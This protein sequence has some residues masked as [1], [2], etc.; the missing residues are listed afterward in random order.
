M[1][2]NYKKWGM[3]ALSAFLWMADA[4]AQLTL[5]K[6]GKA[7]S[8]IVLSEKSEINRQAADLLQEFVQRISGA[9]LP[10]VEGKA[11]SGDVVI[12][13]KS[14]EAGEDGFT[15][16][17]E[18][19]QLKITSGGDKGSIY[20]V[21][22]LLE[23]YMGVSYYAYQAYTLTPSK[24]IT[25]PEIHLSETPA[26]RYRQSFSYG[27]DDPIYKMWFRLE[28][29][30]DVFIDNM[31]VHTFDRL[32]P[33][34]VYGKDHPEYY[35][36]ING[37]HRPGNHSQ[38]CLTNPD[39][40]DFVVKKLDSIFK[41]NPDKKLISVSQN[42]G[43]NTFCTCENCRKVYEEEGSPAGAYIRFM[44]KLAERFPDKEISTLA[45]LFTMHPPK[46]VKPLPNVNIMLCD[47][48]CM[49]EV[50]LTDNASGRDFVKALEGWSAISNNIFVWDYGINFDNMVSCFPNFHVLQKNIQLF[51]KNHVTMHFS[52]VNGSKGTDFSEMRAY[53]LGKLM[54]DPYQ[55]A[56]S[57]MRSFMDGYY[58]AAAPYLYQYQKIM[59]GGLLASGI[60]LWIYDSPVTH[61]NGMLNDQLCKTYDELFD[62]A[63]AAVASDP[64]R[65]DR[66]Q[67]SRLSLIYSELEIARTKTNQDVAKVRQQLDYFRQQCRK[68]GIKSL[69]E[70]SNAPEDYCDLYEKRFLPQAEKSKALGAKVIWLQKPSERYQKIA[71]TALTDGL[72]GGTTFV[73][74]WVGWE[75]VDGSFILDLGEEQEF[76]SVEAD[77]LHQ[78]GQWILLPEK[79]TYSISTDNQT[80]QPFGSFSFAEDRAPQV[81]FVGGKVTSDKPV[82][83]RYIKVEVDA[84][85]MCP[86]WHYGVGHPAW[87]FVDEVTVL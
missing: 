59:Q 15:L 65:L 40:Y 49:R 41:A 27:C 52:Q 47:I 83:A 8:R 78:L 72:F 76:S 42:D 48:D 35:S 12:G 18:Q 60:N 1:K 55:N 32:M 69:N 46:K 56:D 85:G 30:K 77:F 82:K 2:L 66:V 68:F 74:S 54:W 73:E 44:N 19:N 64:V 37:E 62:Q 45:Y 20:G 21:V 17:T 38:W 13:G 39:V 84:I 58:G 24:T 57:L 26:F 6:D 23:K 75:G 87:F 43:N 53:M 50:P 71:D 3:V 31:W 28:E 81:K 67:L 33:S 16:C 11:K 63:E 86:A 80:Y 61:K 79:V 9:S 29:P 4:S 34:D 36:Y 14:A 70:R 22:T 25:L 51:K 5:V 7:V 10:I